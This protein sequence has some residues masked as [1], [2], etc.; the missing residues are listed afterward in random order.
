MPITP[1]MNRK[2]SKPK[3]HNLDTLLD[4][5][6]L[7]KQPRGSIWSGLQILETTDQRGNFRYLTPKSLSADAARQYE[8]TINK[9]F[10]IYI[11]LKN[12]LSRHLH[13]NPKQQKNLSQI[14][15]IHSANCLPLAA[16]YPT[17]RYN[18]N[19]KQSKFDK[20]SAITIDFL[21]N[22]LNDLAR[23]LEFIDVFPRNEIG[24]IDDIMF[25]L[26][27]ENPIVIQQAIEKMSYQ[28]KIDILNSYLADKGEL[29]LANATYQWQ[30]NLSSLERLQLFSNCN[31]IIGEITPRGGYDV[32]KIID[33]A[34]LS[35][36]YQSAFD[37]SYELFAALQA[38]GQQD[39]ASNTCLLGHRQ[40]TR[41]SITAQQARRI[42]QFHNGSLMVDNLIEKMFSK[43]KTLHP[44]IFN[45]IKLK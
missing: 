10:E 5:I 1:P 11:E 26:S 12:K 45:D 3:K 23:R 2:V 8:T 15:T 19:L 43:T 38:A 41:V 36:L 17:Q 4:V 30:I 37:L 22:N 25:E 13:S 7:I 14:A 35:D 20:T 29:A 24:L 18:P 32:P 9:Q 27:S 6:T 33:D 21:G 39:I 40:P 34:G 42:F 44:H 31:I 16:L 28:N